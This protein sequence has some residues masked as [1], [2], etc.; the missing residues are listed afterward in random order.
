MGGMMRLFLTALMMLFMAAA[1]QAQA[2]V[3]NDYMTVSLEAGPEREGARTVAIVMTPQPK[4]H[5]YW[6]NPGAAGIETQAVWTLPEGAEASA[7]RYPVPDRFV[8]SGIMNYVFLP[9]RAL[10]VDLTGLPT[11][12]GPVSLRVDYLVCDDK[13]C[14]P[15]SA[16]LSADL[17]DIAVDAQ[18]MARWEAEQ[19]TVLEADGRLAFGENG[20]RLSFAVPQA[21][22]VAEAYF[23]PLE[24]GLLD[25]NAAQAVSRDGERLI[26]ETVRSYRSDFETVSGVL[27]LMLANGETLGLAVSAERGDVEAAGVPLPGSGGVTGAP[28]EA[29][30]GAGAL[31]LPVI[32]GLAVLGGLLLNIMPCVFPILSLKALSLAKGGRSEGAARSE[33]LFYTAGIL[34]A[35]LA[36]GGL[37]LALRAGGASVGWAFQLQDPRIVFLL[38]MLVMAI[39]LNLAG[40]FELPSVS[41]SGDGL[42]ARSD[43][44]GAF[45]TGV[46][47]AV[48]AT[49]CTGPF[50]GAALGAALILSGPG[51]LLVFAGLGLGLALPFL[52]IGFV[53][54]LRRSLPKPGP[55][56]ETFRRLLSVPMFVTA[57]G[58][59][60]VLGSQA[61]VDGLVIGL[62]GVLLL[63]LALWWL[64]TARARTVPLMAALGS[65]ALIFAVPTGSAPALASGAR[66]AVLAAAPFSPERLAALTAEGT[67]TFTYFTADWCITCK[68]NERGALAS[69]DVAAHFEAA[70]IETLV[71]DW[72]S[73]DPVITAFLTSHGRAGVPL[74]VFY[75][76]AGGEEVLPQILTVERLLALEPGDV[77]D[78]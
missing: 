7:I 19:P 39:A 78:A 72:T 41:V 28:M 1:A 64:G 32:F 15:E 13:L 27:K 22:E 45:A 12:G 31:S 20:V 3:E 49:P 51:A 70:G 35:V 69:A 29:G 40:L 10:L 55:W 5:T 42:L 14:V 73:P 52:L 59:A 68:V 48:I 18:R 37:L 46:L 67:P 57:L 26:I 77:G 25:Y 71:G 38:L 75:D 60:Y 23:F 21:D 30:A 61:G 6:K 74:Y 2:V 24:D 44:M 8:Q 56:M 50:M 4:W 62:T 43:G 34:V 9:E 76:G 17:D 66:T 58:L 11:G 47:A 16:E 63:G 54:A 33:A 53:P 36:L 65:L